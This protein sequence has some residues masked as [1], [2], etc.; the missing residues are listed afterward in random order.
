MSIELPQNEW[1]WSFQKL[2]Q[3]PGYI[4]PGIDLNQIMDCFQIDVVFFCVRSTNEFRKW[5]S[6]ELFDWLNTILWHFHFIFQFLKSWKLLIKMMT[7]SL[8]FID[9]LF[10]FTSQIQNSRFCYVPSQF[11]RERLG[12]FQ[13]NSD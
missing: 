9:A 3:L 1:C 8:L 10:L 11:L 13:K 4:S 2:L 7:F 12:V 5:M 6:S